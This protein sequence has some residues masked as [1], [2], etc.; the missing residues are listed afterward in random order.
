TD[1]SGEFSAVGVRNGTKL[2]I[3]APSYRQ[4]T[5]TVQSGGTSSDV[6]TIT[7]APSE[8]KVTVVDASSNKP[9]AGV[10]GTANGVGSKT[11]ADGVVTLKGITADTQIS[12]QAPGYAPVT[13]KAGNEVEITLKLQP[14]SLQGRAV[15]AASKSTI[16]A[17]LVLV[18]NA[19]GSLTPTLQTDAQGK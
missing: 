9:G 16:A 15:D 1:A 11:D 3:T 6:A 4:V 7:L 19:D 12:V 18:P 5:V 14:T 13:E 2:K 8:L 17:A 10:R